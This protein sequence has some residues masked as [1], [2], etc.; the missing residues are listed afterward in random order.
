MFEFVRHWSR[1]D[2][3]DDD[4][5]AEN[6]RLVL[7]TEAVDALS[8]RGVDAS[9]STIAR[10][11]GIDQ[12]GASRLVKDAVTAELLVLEAGTSDRRRRSARVTGTGQLHL[13][14][15]HAWQEQVFERLTA[16]WSAPKRRAFQQAMTELLERSNG[17]SS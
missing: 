4:Q 3:A 16:G 7:V 6:G 1:R 14:C 12:S 17:A 15:A 11:I 13:E 5:I 2:A 8:R 10:E 9:I